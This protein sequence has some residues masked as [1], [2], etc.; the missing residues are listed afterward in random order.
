MEKAMER[1]MYVFLAAS[2]VLFILAVYFLTN[3]APA[4]TSLANPASVYCEKMGYTDKIVTAADGSQSGV[5][6]FP[7][8][9]ECDEWQF[10]RGECG[11]KY[12]K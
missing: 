8:G 2:A 1:K 7:D 12:V 9:S 10:Y 5:C 6:V 3:R 4:S 11:Q